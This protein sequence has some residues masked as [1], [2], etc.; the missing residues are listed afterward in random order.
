MKNFSAIEWKALKYREAEYLKTM[1]CTLLY[2]RINLTDL[3]IPIDWSS[4]SFNRKLCSYEIIVII[5][6]VVKLHEEW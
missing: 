5:V 6:I 3:A 1:N 2:C 4:L